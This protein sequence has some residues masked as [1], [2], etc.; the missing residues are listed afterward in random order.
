MTKLCLILLGAAAILAAFPALAAADGDRAARA[1]EEAYAAR[2]LQSPQ[3]Q[4]FVGGA[5][6]IVI[7][8]VVIAAIAVLVYFLFIHHHH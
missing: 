7:A 3:L 6:G 2:E 4:E 8:I 5:H 1:E